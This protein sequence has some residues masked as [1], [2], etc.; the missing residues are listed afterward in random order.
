MYNCAL[1]G[2]LLTS[3]DVWRDASKYDKTK[4]RTIQSINVAIKMKNIDDDYDEEYDE[5]KECSTENEEC[6]VA[7]YSISAKTFVTN[8]DAP[9]FENML[10]RI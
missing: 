10:V 9:Q 3:E 5:E 8:I 2:I 4:K 1:E 6:S 7:R